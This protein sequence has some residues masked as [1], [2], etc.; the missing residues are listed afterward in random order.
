MKR[1]PNGP[2]LA[3]LL[4]STVL[5][6][7]TSVILSASPG[8]AASTDVGPAYACNN[9]IWTQ[10]DK[11]G[12]P[13]YAPIGSAAGKYNGTSSTGTL[14]YSMTVTQQRSTTLEAGASMSVG[15]GIAQ[16][17][18][19]FSIAV[20]N[21]TTTG[22]TATDTMS[23]PAHRYGYDQPKVEIQS[24]HIRDLQESGLCVLHTVRDYGY[25][26]AIIT[27]PFFSEC[28]S[29]GPCTPKP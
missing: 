19:S 9:Q 27:Y 6:L 10:V 26:D 16:I 29:T 5:V 8:S 12:S 23:V 14:S 22:W 1:K 11:S 28:T 17:Q 4:L 15:W 2:R 3:R 18:A 7:A 24:Y 13:T 21:S 25:I 20:T